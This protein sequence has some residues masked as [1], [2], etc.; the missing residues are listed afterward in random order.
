MKAQPCAG[1]RC[2]AEGYAQALTPGGVGAFERHD[3]PRPHSDLRHLPNSVRASELVGRHAVPL[4]LEMRGTWLLSAIV[5][6][7]V[8]C[9]Q[10]DRL[11]PKTAGML[12]SVRAVEQAEPAPVAETRPLPATSEVLSPAQI[13]AQAGQSVVVVITP[14][15]RGAGFVVGPNLVATCLHVI[16]GADRVAVRTQ[17]GI[18]HAAHSV[19]AYAKA[20][21]LAL[22]SV[23]DLGAPRL[24]LGDFAAVAP[25]DPVTVI[26]HPRGLDS[27]VSTGIVS[28]L[29]KIDPEHQLLQITAP[30]SPGSSGGPVFNQRG[31]VIGVTSFL[32]RNGQE[33]NFAVPVAALL[34]LLGSKS[35]P[36]ALAEFAQTTAERKEP[37]GAPVPASAP[38]SVP[39]RPSLP[40]KVAGFTYGTTL[41]QVQAICATAENQRLA[42]LGER[43][44]TQLRVD[45][46][47]ATC[48]FAPEPL[49][50]V[51]QVDLKLA[52]NRLVRI[53]PVASSDE[54]A[55]MRLFAKY[56]NPRACEV[57]GKVVRWTPE[58]ERRATSCAWFP[59]GGDLYFWREDAKDPSLVV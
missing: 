32:L 36:T 38:E 34:N 16:A 26:G 51:K 39:G 46:E 13:A 3:A 17:D 14:E 59:D 48:P 53:T 19:V 11:P 8:G 18:E 40:E 37:E 56:G 55:R 15:G 28:A 30:I 52:A 23:D 29:R 47:Y 9:G 20:D 49:E 25:G 58:A 5:V 45:G 24:R 2:P 43:Y 21:D 57:R 41:A 31:E 7:S 22:L 50:L 33:L 6:M 10:S 44:D 1:K 27:S 54:S 35:A 12:P 42:S 4:L